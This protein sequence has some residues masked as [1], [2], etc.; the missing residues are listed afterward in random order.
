MG[1][2]VVRTNESMMQLN[3]KLRALKLMVRTN[4]QSQI[5]A[6]IQD[7]HFLWSQN[8]VDERGYPAPLM[9]HAVLY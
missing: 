9:G 8:Y 3:T 2:I 6:I 5:P 4:L 7:T 1:G